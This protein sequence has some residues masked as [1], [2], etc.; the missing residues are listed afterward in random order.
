MLKYV[1]KHVVLF[2]I[3]AKKVLK[4]KMKFISIF[5]S[6]LINTRHISIKALEMDWDIT[7]NNFR[8]VLCCCSFIDN[9]YWLY[10]AF[11]L[12]IDISIFSFNMIRLMSL[13]HWNVSPILH[14]HVQLLPSWSWTKLSAV[15]IILYSSQKWRKPVVC[16][17]NAFQNCTLI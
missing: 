3:W 2:G 6:I 15:D 1:W 13:C 8:N 12:E 7:M 17:H 4:Q 14:Y 16:Q 9:G 10:S 5:I 11:R